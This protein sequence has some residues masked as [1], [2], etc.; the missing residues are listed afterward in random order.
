MLKKQ[1]INQTFLEDLLESLIKDTPYSNNYWYN[2]NE[3]VQQQKKSMAE[4]DENS[5]KERKT[6]VEAL[7][8]KSV[9]WNK[10]A[11]GLQPQYSIKDI[12]KI[13]EEVQAESEVL[14][15][16]MKSVIKTYD[17]K[18]KDAKLEDA[19]P[20][21]EECSFTE[22]EKENTLLYETLDIDRDSENR[23]MKNAD[24]AEGI[25]EENE[26]D[27]GLV[28]SLSNA[29]SQ[30]FD[31]CHGNEAKKNNII[32]SSESTNTKPKE[33]AIKNKELKGIVLD[34][35][36]EAIENDQLTHMDNIHNSISDTQADVDSKQNG[37]Y[38]KDGKSF[39]KSINNLKE[40]DPFTQTKANITTKD[41]S[42]TNISEKSIPSDRESEVKAVKPEELDKKIEELENQLTD[43]LNDETINSEVAELRVRILEF[44]E[45]KKKK[46]K[47]LNERL[48]SERSARD[49][50]LQQHQNLLLARENLQVR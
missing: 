13:I 40:T 50:S 42:K 2:M 34:V 49:L 21:S 45:S 5:S 46:M 39:N 16:K 14:G 36:V 17:A 37:N 15:E 18:V 8:S 3:E 47:Y 4:F 28:S 20:E 19:K 23:D 30:S 12:D 48:E 7:E 10:Q 6:L 9:H 26:L 29:S 1:G 24:L 32:V 27:I 35:P 44:D 33:D 11:N 41:V 25:S 43:A 38:T 31:G 22:E